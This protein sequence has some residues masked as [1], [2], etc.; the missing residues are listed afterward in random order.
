M[1]YTE[2]VSLLKREMKPALGVTEPAAIALASAKAYSLVGGE[3]KRIKLELDAGIYKNAFSCAIP[4][5]DEAGNEMSALLGVLAGDPEADLEVLKNIKE[6]DATKAQ[7]LRD[8]N[9]VDIEVKKG[10]THIYV[11]ATVETDQGSARAVIENEHANVVLLQLNGKTVFEKAEEVKKEVVKADEH[12]DAFDIKKYSIKDFVE[13]VDTV[14][15]ADIRFTLEAI[16]TNKELAELGKKGAGMSVARTLEELKKENLL[17]DDIML[18]AQQ[19][20][21]YAV[22]ARLGGLP[23][24]AMSI[25]G[26]GSHGIIA[27]MPL[28]AFAE[29]KGIGEERLAR[30]IALSYLL[31]LYIKTYSGRLSAFCGCA[32]ASGT[33]AGAALV[34]LLG[35]TVEQV[36]Y[37]IKNMAANITG[38]ICDGG[39]Y[40]CSLKA[41]T[42]AGAA[43][44]AALLALKN[45]AIPSNSGIV[46]DTPERTIQN[47][48]R[49]ADPGMLETDNVILDVMIDGNKA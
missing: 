34:Y 43:V 31:T 20:T 8:K 44:M 24:P 7:E 48:G 13:F 42:A 10:L 28:A 23:K 37:A 30:A 6:A 32:I 27:T 46:G 15:F 29:R 21:G 2:I 26:S 22:D 16:K 11:D 36:G 35:G 12:E 1:E 47:M 14:P 3:L 45:I 5:T 33:S 38:M 39:N 49:V 4:G 9:M 25:C 40:G 41:V 19:L 18:Y 17:A